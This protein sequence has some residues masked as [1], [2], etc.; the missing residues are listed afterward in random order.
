MLYSLHKFTLHNGLRVILQEIPHCATVSVNVLY[1]VGSKDEPSHQ[2]GLAHLFEHLMFSGSI[3]IPQYDKPLQIAGGSNNAYTT[4]DIT[5]Y[6]CMLPAKN[7]E[8]AF[9]LESDRMLGLAFNEKGLE[10]QK[11]VVYEEFKERYMN[12]PYGDMGA[13]IRE[14][15]FQV[16]PYRWMTIGKELIH[17]EQ[18]KMDTIKQFFNSFYNPSNAILSIVGG[19]TLSQIKD[20]CERWFSNIPSGKRYDRNLPK[21]PIINSPRKKEVERDV[22]A[23]MIIK[24]YPM[25]GRLKEGYYTGDILSD[26][27]GAGSSSRLYYTLV[28]EKKLFSSI[29]CYQ[30]GLI[31]TGVLICEGTLLPH[32]D[33]TTAEQAL[34]EEIDA[35]RKGNITKKEWQ[36]SIHRI[37][38]N[39]CFEDMGITARAGSL[40]FYEMMGDAQWY[41]DE[42]IKYQQCSIERLQEDA[43]KIFDTSK[44]C[45]LYYNRKNR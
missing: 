33:M 10:T 40:A 24:C 31:D 17:I 29:S 11:K 12:K 22:P 7:I 5:N 3:H 1:N 30:L 15:V 19:V 36:K 37:E 13:L 45:T 9:W 20:L 21:E 38:N 25:E 23:S 8:T 2:T 26:I 43:K 4:S 41:F 28:K 6:Y 44:T 35:L 27:L 18:V 39:L 42:L 14:L 16:H 34:E 32:V